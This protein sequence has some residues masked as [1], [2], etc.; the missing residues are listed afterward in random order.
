MIVILVAIA[1]KEIK[2]NMANFQMLS[3]SQHSSVGVAT[4]K[5]QCSRPM[6]QHHTVSATQ[7]QPPASGSKGEVW[8]P[9]TRVKVQ[10]SIASVLWQARAIGH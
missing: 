7:Q 1:N 2:L 6:Q 10:W 4:N 9:T 3:G 8:L 5:Q